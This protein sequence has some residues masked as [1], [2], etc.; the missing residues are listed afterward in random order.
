MD[1]ASMEIFGLEIYFRKCT[2]NADFLGLL[3]FLSK[4]LRML[5]SRVTLGQ[6]LFCLNDLAFSEF[7]GGCKMKTNWIGFDGW[8]TFVKF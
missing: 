2:R 1:R 6:G 7:D 5:I 4:L 3:L 8:S